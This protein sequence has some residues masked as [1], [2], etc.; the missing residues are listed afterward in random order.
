MRRRRTAWQATA[1]ATGALTITVTAAVLDAPARLLFIALAAI[2]VGGIAATWAIEWRIAV[3]Q[4]RIH[5]QR[6]NRTDEEN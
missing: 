4:R 2:A 3:N 5:R 1:F 6:T